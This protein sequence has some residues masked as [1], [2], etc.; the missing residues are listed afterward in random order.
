MLG[1]LP[2]Q[3]PNKQFILWISGLTEDSNCEDFS[4]GNVMREM[5]AESLAELV[6]RRAKLELPSGQM[7]A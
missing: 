5:R 7:L 2:G 4:V 1:V 3:A 6:R